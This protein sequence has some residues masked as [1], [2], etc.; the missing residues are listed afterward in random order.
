MVKSEYIRIGNDRGG[1]VE[2]TM[3][4]DR[5]GRK[6]ETSIVMQTP[7]G[8]EYKL[9]HPK[10]VSGLL[11]RSLAEVLGMLDKLIDDSQVEA[12]ET[13]KKVRG[14]SGNARMLEIL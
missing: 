4:P 9:D 12:R 2:I 7:T 8:V 13:T 6:G 1:S 3:R 10:D 11:S 5:H 14:R